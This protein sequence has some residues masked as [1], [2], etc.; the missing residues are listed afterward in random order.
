MFDPLH[1]LIDSESL[2]EVKKWLGGWLICSLKKK[3]NCQNFI[4][5]AIYYFDND[6]LQGLY[7][8]S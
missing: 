4:I 6:H 3:Q 7:Q 8:D 2:Q 1:K 5:R